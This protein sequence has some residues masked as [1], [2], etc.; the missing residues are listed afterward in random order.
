MSLS[1]VKRWPKI[2]IV[3][4]NRK[5]AFSGQK[6]SVDTVKVSHSVPLMSSLIVTFTNRFIFLRLRKCH[7]VQNTHA[8]MGKKRRTRP[9]VRMKVYGLE[10]KVQCNLSPNFPQK[11]NWLLVNWTIKPIRVHFTRMLYMTKWSDKMPLP[12]LY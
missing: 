6:G 4:L 2:K 11:Q 8:R 1:P 12:S 5:G 9:M 3:P 10:K 7:G